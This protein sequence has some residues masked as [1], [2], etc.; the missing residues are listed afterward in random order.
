M[1]AERY[2]RRTRSE[3]VRLESRIR[4]VEE[5]D[6]W[7]R[8]IYLG[9]RIHNAVVAEADD[10]IEQAAGELVHIGSR[11]LRQMGAPDGAA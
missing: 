5:R 10:V 6:A 11:R 9:N 1:V 7:G 2:D 3:L 8:V 4:R